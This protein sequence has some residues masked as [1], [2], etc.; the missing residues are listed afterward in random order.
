MNCKEVKELVDAYLDGE[1][2]PLTNQNIEGHL[3]E[4]SLCS[5]AYKEQ[6]AFVG[7]IRGAAPYHKSPPN[8]RQRIQASLRDQIAESPVDTGQERQTQVPGK[9]RNWSEYLFELPWRRL[10][11]AAAFA[12][13]LYEAWVTYF[14]G[15]NAATPAVFIL[16]IV[17]LALMPARFVEEGKEGRA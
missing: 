7:A 2:D 12:L 15:A 9:T 6:S 5:Q 4:C 10:G 14:A 17:V 11:L 8:L 1:L 13:G 16:I 3:K